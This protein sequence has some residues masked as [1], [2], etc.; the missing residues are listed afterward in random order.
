VNTTES[1]G[2]TALHYAAI[3]GQLEAV[4]LLL[5]QHADL[6][7]IDKEHSSTPLGWAAWG[8]DFVK[9]AGGDYP[10][11]IRALLDAGSRP[12]PGGYVPE[13]EEARAALEG[14]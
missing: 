2:A 11:T 14:R 1:G 5:A 9:K 4:R 8:S 3:E 10:G 7:I 13:N 6:N 12:Y